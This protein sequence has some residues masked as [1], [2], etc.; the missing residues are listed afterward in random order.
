MAKKSLPEI[1]KENCIKHCLIQ[2]G[3]HVIVGVSGGAD[4]VCL[5]LVLYKLAPVMDLKLTAVHLNHGM[6]GG[7][8]DGD[9]T[10]VESLCSRLGMP[11]KVF[12]E[13][14]GE[15][16]SALKISEEEAGREARYRL[17]SQVMDEE[18]ANVIAVAHNL[19]DNAETVM[20]NILR[21]CGLDGLCGM[22]VRN[23]SIIR[24]LLTVSRQEIEAWLIKSGQPYRTDSS[25]LTD[26]YFRNRIRNRLFPAIQEI[27]GLNPVQSLTRL[28][29]LAAEDH[30]SLE[31]MA[32]CLFREW[33]EINK[34]TVLSFSRASLN[35]M[36]S[37]VAAR[38]IRLAWEKL[39]GD[40]KNLERT[41]VEA[42]LKLC[43]SQTTGKKLALPLGFSAW[44]DYD[45]LFMGIKE[46][47]SSEAYAYPLV[48]PG[49]TQVPEASGS[50]HAE[51][52]DRPPG[53][54]LKEIKENSSIQVFDYL[55]LVRGINIR[56][57][58]NGDRIHPSRSP[59]EKK[60][61]EFFID[62]KVSQE[63][64]DN[65]PMVAMGRD[66]IWIVGMRTSE[67]FRAD[68]HTQSFLKLSWIPNE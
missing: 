56:N 11:L 31:R 29:R 30:E 62:R 46:A 15:M 47:S 35:T 53:L 28:S 8:S 58:R 64:R 68:Q 38:I 4:S 63:E 24:P 18:Q 23:G 20:M 12:S 10:F 49:V 48:L 43:R 59:G 33:Y 2:P 21:G 37:A 66:V 25:N 14:I 17:F 3:D 26:A 65:I 60:L 50:L 45:R 34:E 61:K 42:I 44:L 5:L 52:L 22:D 7:E 41:H 6:R 1:V 19:E 32:A 51:L 13:K 40:R 39:K 27:T 16:A 36:D 9:Q 67:K 54:L 55:K 57:R